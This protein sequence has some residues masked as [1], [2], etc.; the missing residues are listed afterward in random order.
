MIPDSNSVLRNFQKYPI[1]FELAGSFAMWTDP[2]T[3]PCPDS[4]PIPPYASIKGIFDNI[5][6]IRTAT[7]VP[8]KIEICSPIKK[9]TFTYN[10]KSPLVN[11][12]KNPK[13]KNITRT[14]QIKMNILRN[15]VYRVY[16]TTY[17]T[18]STFEIEKRFQG[19]NALH[20]LQSIIMRQIKKGQS[21]GDLFMGQK[22][23]PVNYIGDFREGFKVQE[24]INM[25]IPSFPIIH[26]EQDGTQ[27][28][29][30]NSCT[31]INGVYHYVK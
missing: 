28:I 3:T 15:V 23:F 30:P 27:I 31:I 14:T 10:S 9:E 29:S 8:I 16:A 17:K 26:Y 21:W 6:K 11:E 1:V 19:I 7:T 12:K 13:T 25:Y 5:S 24:E 4:F 2:S 18:M 22:M 20:A